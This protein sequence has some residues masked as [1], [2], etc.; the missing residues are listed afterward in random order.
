MLRNSWC[1]D[2]PLEARGCTQILGR[3]LSRAPVLIQGLCTLFLVQTPWTLEGSLRATKDS[4]YGGAPRGQ[5]GGL[6]KK[7]QPAA[8]CNT[9]C[10]REPSLCDLTIAST[11]PVSSASQC[12]S[13][14]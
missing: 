12:P 3:S 13:Q 7:H 5:A 10:C 11:I 4:K 8:T 14:C 2:P 6:H 9:D 1:G